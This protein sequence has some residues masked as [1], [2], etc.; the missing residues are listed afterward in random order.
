MEF[1][2]ADKKAGIE[3]LIGFS[4]FPDS[5]A[6]GYVLELQIKL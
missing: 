4:F 5:V 3:S 6:Q 1:S 2:F